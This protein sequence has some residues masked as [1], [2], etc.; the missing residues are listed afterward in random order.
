MSGERYV[1]TRDCASVLLPTLT[2][3]KHHV[4]STDFMLLTFAHFPFGRVVA[5][6]GKI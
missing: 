2:H 6:G 1:W 5:W 3:E 4:A